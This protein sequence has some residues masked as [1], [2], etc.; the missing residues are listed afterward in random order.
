MITLCTLLIGML[1]AGEPGRAAELPAEVKTELLGP[2]LAGGPRVADRWGDGY[3]I[4]GDVLLCDNG[5]VK[6]RR[7][8][9]WVVDVAQASPAPIYCVA[10][11]KAEN[12]GGQP[13][14]HYA[15]QVDLQYHDASPLEVHVL[16]FSVGTHD[17]QRKAFLLRPEKRVKYVRVH[18]LMRHHTGKAWFRAPEVR[19]LRSAEDRATVPA[20]AVLDLVD[21]GPAVEMAVLRTAVAEMLSSDLAQV[22]GL[23]VVERVRVGQFLS[24]S[25]LQAGFTDQANTRRAGQALAADYLLGGSVQGT[26]QQMRIELVLRRVGRERP[27]GIWQE[28]ATAETLPQVEALLLGKV[29]AALNIQSN[30]KTP[31]PRPKAVPGNSPLVAIF[32]LRNLSPS[33]RL[34]PMESGFADIL[35]AKLAAWK[36]VRM[37]DREHVSAVLR[38]QQIS[39]AGLADPQTAIRVGKLLGAER[40]VYG[41]FLELGATLRIDLRLADAPSAS[42]VRA[43]TATGRADRPAELLENL[44]SRLAADLSLAPPAVAKPKTQAAAGDRQLEADVHSANA[45]REHQA[46]RYLEAARHFERV[47]LVDPQ[48]GEA[49]VGRARAWNLYRDFNKA[50]EAAEQGLATPA[51][52]SGSELRAK[53]LGCLV[54]AYF[55]LGRD[56]EAGNLYR[57]LTKELWGSERNPYDRSHEAIKLSLEGRH[58]EAVAMMQ[59]VVDL[60]RDKGTPQS[61]ALALQACYGFLIG[62]CGQVE[63]K[64]IADG[65]RGDPGRRKQLAVE[66]RDSALRSIPILDTILTE[67]ERHPDPVWDQWAWGLT[68]WG[69]A[70]YTDEEGFRRSVLSD[71]ER[72]ATYRRV[73]RAFP[74]LS[75]L[76]WRAMKELAELEWKAEHWPQALAAYDYVVSHPTVRPS[77]RLPENSDMHYSSR[78]QI[79]DHLIEARTRKAEILVRLKRIDEAVDTY[80]QIV[81][82]MGLNHAYGPMV[83]RG[84]NELGRGPRF[85]ERCA[86]VWGGGDRARNA[87][88]ELLAP[89]GFTTH[90]HGIPRASAAELAPYRLVILVRPGPLPFT[91]GEVMALRS[92]VAGGGGLLVVLS[93]GWHPA[94]PGIHNPLLALFQLHAGRDMIV[95]EWSKH[96]ADHP[97]TQSISPVIA[98][99]SAGLE[100]PETSAIIRSRD[101][102]LLAA[103]DYR[104]GRVVASSFGQW[105]LPERDLPRGGTLVWANYNSQYRNRWALPPE[106]GE[107]MQL[108]LLANVLKWLAAQDNAPATHW[109]RR[110]RM[111]AAQTMARR[112]QCELASPDELRPAMDRWIAEAEPGME[113]E[114]ALWAAGEASLQTVHNVK[115]AWAIH[116]KWPH[117]AYPPPM[118]ADYFRRLPAEFPNSPLKPYAQWR[119]ADCARRAA[120]HATRDPYYDT[121]FGVTRAPQRAAAAAAELAKLQ[122]PEGTYPWAWNRLGLGQCYL[123]AGAPAAAAKQFQSVADRMDQGSEK[124]LATLDAGLA[125]RLAGETATAVRYYESARDMPDI[126]W[127]PHSRYDAWAP[128]GD[129]GLPWDAETKRVATDRLRRLGATSKQP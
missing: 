7:G 8:A 56:E 102:V 52:K 65:K 9:G 95:V 87:Y 10:W 127:T 12:V 91:P 20:L 69:M 14:G 46:G 96:L 45:D 120:F 79:S 23:R 85:P 29:L 21:R 57:Q 11:S 106:P 50:I 114:E 103:L 38:E 35:Q 60:Q 89:L 116:E 67:C 97:I 42:L 117:G 26:N 92:F 110:E 112:A 1:T 86:L 80:Q 115:L 121:M 49:A 33:A 48:N 58:H 27:L 126:P 32:G 71:E 70:V 3:Q 109:A 94:Q 124:T 72:V 119:L 125:L 108:P 105:F 43:E 13:D 31:P 30:R 2:D 77:Q 61:Y 73:V 101:R 123:L 75:D 111:L 88:A 129:D 93:P 63:R 19:L 54:T 41:S 53:L 18:L 40:L 76:V 39:I 84:L 64:M 16:C 83:L 74:H 62:E 98:K 15:L 22:E 78:S 59:A 90:R 47:L 99:T 122:L 82:E 24:E 68:Y 128:L 5:P 55:G 28:A 37:V 118:A 100:S 34:T 44:A 25:K 36:N 51:A 81:T 113:R 104:G 66:S 107:R 6:G 4:E 17:W